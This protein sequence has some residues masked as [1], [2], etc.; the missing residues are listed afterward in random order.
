MKAYPLYRLKRKIAVFLSMALLLLSGCAKTTNGVEV[1]RRALIQGLALDYISEGEQAF[2]NVSLRFFAPDSSG[3]SGNE[4]KGGGSESSENTGEQT[5]KKNASSEGENLLSGTGGTVMEALANAQSAYGKRITIDHCKYLIFGPSVADPAI[6][7]KG[8]RER[9]QLNPSVKLYM[10][11]ETASAG[12]LLADLP[13]DFLAQAEYAEQNLRTFSVDM[14]DFYR[15]WQTTQT[16]LLP[17]LSA[18][19]EEKIFSGGMLLSAV[20]R[21]AAEPVISNQNGRFSIKTI[22]LLS[23]AQKAMESEEQE[24]ASWKLYAFQQKFISLQPVSEQALRGFLLVSG[25]ASA[26]LQ[27][28]E[29]D[30][31]PCAAIIDKTQRTAAMPS[32][33]YANTDTVSQPEQGEISLRF[34]GRLVEGADYLSSDRICE[35]LRGRILSDCHAAELEGIPLLAGVR[36]VRVTV[37]L[38]MERTDAF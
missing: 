4:E 14:V 27:S 1:S 32:V 24:D 17:R 19:A 35:A 31:V 33:R 9:E 16:A 3:G 20:D 21:D 10:A 13:G 28:F 30:G 37:A 5:D 7:L 11:S 8:L 18:E 22:S 38:E 36:N 25:R 26:F 34:T 2:W 12:E 6:G 23:P 29:A 15:T